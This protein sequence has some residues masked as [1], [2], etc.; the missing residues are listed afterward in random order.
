MLQWALMCCHRHSRWA[1]SEPRHTLP[2]SNSLTVDSN[3]SK[4]RRFARADVRCI[5]FRS[6]TSLNEVAMRSKFTPQLAVGDVVPRTTSVLFQPHHNEALTLVKGL[7]GF[8]CSFYTS[9]TLPA[10]ME[11][12][13]DEIDWSQGIRDA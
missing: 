7:S 13:A 8:V 6:R 4:A 12:S 10:W 11:I 2:S 3:K 9:I 5:V 1:P